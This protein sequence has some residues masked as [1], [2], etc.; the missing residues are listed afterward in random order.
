MSTTIELPDDFSGEAEF[1]V[2]TT[3]L[4]TGIDTAS[5]YTKH[6]RNGVLHREDGPAVLLEGK[7]YE[8]WI[9]GRLFSEEEFSVYL[10]R[11]KLNESLNCDLKE[12]ENYNKKSK[13]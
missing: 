4:A 9:D 6:Y 1:K 7:P 8:Y 5:I 13:I 12:R 11:K 3:D 10:E 2:I